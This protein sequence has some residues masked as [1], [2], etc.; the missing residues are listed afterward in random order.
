MSDSEKPTPSLVVFER[1]AQLLAEANTI[2]KARE[3]KALEHIKG[4]R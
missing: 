2:Q 3:L 4:K 1:G